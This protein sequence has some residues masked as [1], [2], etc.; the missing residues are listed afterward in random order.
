MKFIDDGGSV[1]L[2]NTGKLIPVYMVLQ[3]RRQPSSGLLKTY[4]SLLK[5]LFASLMTLQP[6]TE[7]ENIY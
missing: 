3:L 5:K 7:T 1:D 4:Q 6:N 2:C